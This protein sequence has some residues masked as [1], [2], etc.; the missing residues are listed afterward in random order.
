MSYDVII[1]GGGPAGATAGYELSRRGLKV[2][3]LEKNSLPRDKTCAGGLSFRVTSLLDF[4]IKEVILNS[5]HGITVSLKGKDSFG[6]SAKEPIA[7]MVERKH[8]DYLLCTRAKESGVELR[9]NEKVVTVNEVGGGVEVTTTRCTYIARILVGADGAN[10]LTSK[11]MGLRGK[12]PSAL[13]LESKVRADRASLDKMNNNVQ[14]D[15]G[16]S[17]SGYG[18]LFPKGDYLSTGIVCLMDDTKK[19]KDLFYDFVK[20]NN[21]KMEGIEKISAHPLPLFHPNRKSFSKGNTLLIGDAAG[22]VDPFLGE[23]IYYAIWS[24]KIASEVILKTLENREI[25]LSPFDKRIRQEMGPHLRGAWKVAKI[26]YSAPD[27]W[28]K[29]LHSWPQIFEHYYKILRGEGGYKDF[30]KT[31]WPKLRN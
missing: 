30:I 9:D 24:A 25:D 29:V 10:S 15:L 22:L 19:P 1:V 8:F 5:I 17:T 28:F 11:I 18:W 20:M 3:L 23:G 27:F 26:I 21:L 7:Y 6:F 12:G 16:Y 2:L 4:D 14:I 13:G 31:L